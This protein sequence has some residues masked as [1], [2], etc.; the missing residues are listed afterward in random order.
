[1]RVWDFAVFA[2]VGLVV[3]LSAGGFAKDP[4]HLQIDEL[5]EL[6][7]GKRLGVLTNGSAR[8]A[9]G[10][11]DVDYLLQNTETTVSAFFGPEHGFRAD[12]AD[13][14]K[15]GD[16][17]D[18]KT[19]VPVY[20]LYGKRQAPTPE[21]L[22]DVDLF[23]FDIPDV[24]V[25][26][27][28]YVWTMTHAME[29]CAKADIPFVVIDRPNPITGTRVEGAVNRKDLG[30]VGRLGHEAAFGV[31][32]R[33]G[34]TAGELAT[35]WNAEWMEPKV[36]LQVI[37]A[38]DWRRNQWWDETGRAFIAP[39][40]NMRTLE[41]ATVYPGTCIFEGTNL[42]EGRGTSAPFEMIGAP[43]VDG[44]AWAAKLNEL[45][46]AG[47]KFEPIT[48]TPEGRRWKGEKCGGVK[49]VVMDREALKAVAMGVHMLQT[50]AKMYPEQVK[51]TDYA[52]RLMATP[53]LRKRIFSEDAEAI[54]S[55]WDKDRAEYEA[56]RE[57]YLLY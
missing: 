13:G 10:L 9:D 33:H 48:F 31:A 41:C 47:V 52:D 16:G 18:P 14:E 32:T 27:Y 25:R 3:N 53:D 55:G 2:A 35:L 22:K 44:E 54:I 12:L 29:A 39:S 50:V 40:P 15:A 42:S 56:L 49:V 19:G 43:F 11:H 8:T 23:V 1:M 28:T 17:I 57:K 24:G 51:I 30:L 45:K 36:K 5:A 6:A 38:R 37:K 26:F 46:L 20:S 21:Q 34:L 4:V 7:K